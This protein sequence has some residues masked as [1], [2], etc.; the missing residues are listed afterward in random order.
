MA[1][2]GHG[3]I[4]SQHLDVLALLSWGESCEGWYSD[5]YVPWI[6]QSDKF[7]HSTHAKK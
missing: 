2:F 6:L 7:F 4:E 5:K 3:E 1:Q